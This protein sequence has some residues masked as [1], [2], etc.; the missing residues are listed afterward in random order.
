MIEYT[1]IQGQKSR[2]NR[3]SIFLLV[4]FPVLLLAMFWTIFLFLDQK[5]TVQIN[6]FT[7]VAPVILVCVGLWFL[8][9]WGLNTKMIQWATGAK[10]LERTENKRVYNIVEN[11]CIA[12]GMKMPAI[13]LIE[14]SSLNAFAS[15]INDSSLLF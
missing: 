12:N 1:G 15:G 5:D 8:I 6:F 9:A 4:L 2:N 3:N 11:L 13:Y 7:Q 14:D 10:T